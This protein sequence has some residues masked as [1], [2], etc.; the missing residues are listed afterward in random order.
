MFKEFDAFLVLKIESVGHLFGFFYLFISWIYSAYTMNVLSFMMDAYRLLNLLFVCAVCLF[1]KGKK[2]EQ[3]SFWNY[4]ELIQLPNL[5][6]FYSLED[7]F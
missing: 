2:Q 1:W 6:V 3:G 5:S 7:M 4:A